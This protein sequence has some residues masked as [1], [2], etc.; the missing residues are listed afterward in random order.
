METPA[1]SV[2]LTATMIAPK[3]AV[4]IDDLTRSITDFAEPDTEGLAHPSR[5][6]RAKRG[7]DA[8]IKSPSA[9]RA[10][11]HHGPVTCSACRITYLPSARPAT[12]GAPGDW[13]CDGCQQPL[14]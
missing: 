14:G 11:H 9:D 12:P 13:V 7:Q 8:R 4:M 6:A 3:R 2:V 5:T 1:K 10:A